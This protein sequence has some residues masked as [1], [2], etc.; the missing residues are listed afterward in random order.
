MISPVTVLSEA[1]RALRSRDLTFDALDD[2]T[3]ELALLAYERGL[4]NSLGEL[5]E[6]LRYDCLKLYRRQLDAMVAV[7]D[8]DDDADEEE[9]VDLGSPERWLEAYEI[10][11]AK[12]DE[13]PQPTRWRLL[14]EIARSVPVMMRP[15]PK[16]AKVWQRSGNLPTPR[17]IAATE[18]QATVDRLNR[19]G[20][21]A[22]GRLPFAL[23]I[24]MT[25]RVKRRQGL[26]E[27]QLRPDGYEWDKKLF[28]SLSAAFYN[29][30]GQYGRSPLHEIDYRFRRNVE[31]ESSAGV[32][33][34][35]E[36]VWR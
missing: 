18:M 36:G 15:R 14:R 9:L 2:W 3:Q 10:L 33:R 4:P 22:S 5:R 11:Q 16:R 7:K 19:L 26:V 1:R 29:A 6:S 23:A 35:A 12:I 21:D 25:I 8:V 17:A 31:I 30:Y 32:F 27:V 13:L 34:Y 28:S 20:F 24:G